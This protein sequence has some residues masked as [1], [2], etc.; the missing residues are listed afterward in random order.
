MFGFPLRKL[1]G[2]SR[3]MFG[4]PLRKLKGKLRYKKL[5]DM[6]G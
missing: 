4:F 3:Y 6:L 5:I 2:E 1:K